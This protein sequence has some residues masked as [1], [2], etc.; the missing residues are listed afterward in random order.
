MGTERHALWDCN[1]AHKIWGQVLRVF[2]PLLTTYT[3]T[4]GLVIW[5]VLTGLPTYESIPEAKEYHF[6]G[7]HAIWLSAKL[8]EHQ[9]SLCVDKQWELISPIITWFIWK[10]RCLMVYR[11]GILSLL[12]WRS[13]KFGQNCL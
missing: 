13:V 2:A 4:W 5:L 11:E 1:R 3:V 7:L 10:R 8:S 12:Q 9:E 6:E